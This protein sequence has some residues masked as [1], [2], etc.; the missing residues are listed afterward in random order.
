MGIAT[1]V[2]PVLAL[3]LLGKV[4]DEMVIEVLATKMGVTGRRQNLEYTVVDREKGD[5]EGTTTEIV[6]D[7]LRLAL[8]LVK[9]VSDSGSC[10]FVY[11]R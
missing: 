3:E 7:D 2:F 11:P 10:G 4:G 1:E 9:T 6:N 5:I 8:G